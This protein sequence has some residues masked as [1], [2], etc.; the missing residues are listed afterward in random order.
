[1]CDKAKFGK[2]KEVLA[3]IAVLALVVIAYSLVSEIN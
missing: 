2:V 3:V 1:M